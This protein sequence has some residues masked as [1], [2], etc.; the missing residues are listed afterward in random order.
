[1]LFSLSST[2]LGL[3]VHQLEAKRFPSNGKDYHRWLGH[4]LQNEGRYYGGHCAG[5]VYGVVCN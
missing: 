2:M 5:V 3:Q 1:M 4:C